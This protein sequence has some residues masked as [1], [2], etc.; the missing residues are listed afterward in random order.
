MPKEWNAETQEY[1]DGILDE[2][3]KEV[4]HF[5]D[6]SDRD[7]AGLV[8]E[9][10]A[11]DEPRFEMLEEEDLVEYVSDWRRRNGFAKVRSNRQALLEDNL[12]NAIEGGYEDFDAD[13]MTDDEIAADVVAYSSDFDMEEAEDLLPLVRNWR[14]RRARERRERLSPSTWLLIVRLVWSI[15]SAAI[16]YFR[17]KK[18]PKS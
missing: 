14:Q 16:A 9:L 10:D 3:A 4:G 13:T 15:G 17:S 11:V 12:A 1:V 5:A 2:Q 6:W 18:G 8:L 7:F